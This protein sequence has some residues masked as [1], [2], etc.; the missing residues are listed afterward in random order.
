MVKAILVGALC[1][2]CT[3][4]GGLLYKAAM[5]DATPPYRQVSRRWKVTES[6]ATEIRLAGGG[7]E[8]WV[9]RRII[10]GSL[11]LPLRLPTEPE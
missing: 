1:L 5:E 7:S 9:W 4:S 10:A 3:R 6:K 8:N 2:P 11:Q